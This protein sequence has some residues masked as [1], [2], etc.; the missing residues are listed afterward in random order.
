MELRQRKESDESGAP[1]LAPVIP[2]SVKAARLLAPPPRTGSGLR[3]DTFFTRVLAGSLLISLPLMA[4]LGVLMYA[5]GLQSS[6]QEAGLQTQASATSTAGR[7]DQWISQSEEYIAQLARGAT[8]ADGRPGPIST[9]LE[10]ATDPDF[11]SIA[12]VNAAGTAIAMTADS[13]DLKPSGQAPW[14]GQALFI[15]TEHYDQQRSHGP[16]LDHLGSDR[17]RQRRVAGRSRRGLG[18]VPAQQFARD[19]DGEPGSPRRQRRP[20]PGRQLRLGDADHRR[21]P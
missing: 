1:A 17:R 15:A 14:F 2:L 11:E 9:S 7:I 4:I 13:A 10:N 3:A 18:R 21:R 8:A 12:L 20:P 16:R 19:R 6:A 5:Q